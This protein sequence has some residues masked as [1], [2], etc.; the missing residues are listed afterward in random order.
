I[1]D[2]IGHTPL[3]KLNRVARDVDAA[4]YVKCE[5]MNP[6]G[7]MKDRMTLNMVDQAETRGDLTPGGTIIEATSGNTGAGLAM[8]AAVRGYH[9]VF[10]MPDK[11]STEKIASLK[12]FGARVVVCP[13]AVEPEDPRSYYSVAKK[14]HADTPNSFYANQ[15]HNQDNPGGH[16]LSTGPEI[17][18]QTEGKIDVFV[19]GMGTG[20]TM[21]GTGRYLKEQK[22]SIQLVGVDPVGSLYYDFVKSQ[23]ITKAF[24]YK[25]EG[26]GEDFFPTTFDPKWI[27]DIVRVDDKE[28]FL[29]ARDLVRLEGL[30]AGGSAGAAVAGAVKFARQA[31]KRQ[32][33]VVLLPDGAA[34]YLSKVF[35]DEWLRE[36]GFLEDEWGLGTVA[37]LLA[38]RPAKVIT[39]KAG[40]R[41]RDVIAKMK[42][43]GISQLPVLSRG[44][45]LGAV[46]EV[47]LL[48]YLAAGE[49]S[50]DTRVDAL[51][52]SDYA[53]VSSQ[54]RIEL[55]QNLL[56]DTRMAI[57]LEG[58]DL[59]GVIT[60]ID[61]ITYLARP[62][63]RRS[64]ARTG[65]KRRKN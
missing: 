24:T 33:I 48:R 22:P 9:C 54:T 5:Y 46:A 32:N 57:V 16:Y 64:A 40:D 27:D 50:L 47:D 18:E 65:R 20:G 34:K 13:T 61:L 6:G 56:A 42:S 10:V 35:N 19:A 11:M 3:V 53:T 43:R 41:V 28:C 44:T 25:V 26:I 7:S 49:H 2:A 12:A 58:D 51:V 39:A 45:L 37:D 30:Y 60:K 59:I 23:R 62:M 1:L 36:N 15:Y 55:V 4:I 14:L 38:H 63:L 52:E 21:A 17:W 29:M 8:I 31:H